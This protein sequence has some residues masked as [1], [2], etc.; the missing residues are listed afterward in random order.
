MTLLND[1]LGV[2][3]ALSVAAAL[4]TATSGSIGRADTQSTVGDPEAPIVGEAL[5]TASAV[6]LDVVGVGRV[7]ETEVDDEDGAYEV[8]ITLADGHQVDVHL[9][10][11]FTVIGQEADG[12]GDSVETRAP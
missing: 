5:A 8:E 3:V 4:A 7:S 10:D 12:F 2:A 6:A 9:D 1:T 11:A